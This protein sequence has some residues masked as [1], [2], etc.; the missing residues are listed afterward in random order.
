MQ[1]GAGFFRSF[2]ADGGVAAGT[3]SSGQ[4]LAE[5][6]AVNGLRLDQRLRIRIENAISDAIEVAQDHAVHRIA[7]ATTDADDLDASRLAGLN[8][9]TF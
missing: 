4:G 6:Q 9:S 8:P 7:S 5:L 3:Q 2:L 1:I